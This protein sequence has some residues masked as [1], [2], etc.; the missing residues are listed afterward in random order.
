MRRILAISLLLPSLF[1]P[2]VAN[3]SNPLDDAS[4]P[5]PARVSTGVVAP[6]IL[7]AVNLSLPTGF[8]QE[9]VPSDAQVSLALIVDEKGQPQDI[10]VVK[11]YNPFWDARVID[12]VRQFRFK[13]GTVSNQPV[14]VDVN[15]TVNI[16]R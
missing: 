4:A 9:F 6:V 14:P 8:N 2:A 15:L 1:F 13:P 3:A 7:D 5:T 16:A 10:H 12:A 11:S